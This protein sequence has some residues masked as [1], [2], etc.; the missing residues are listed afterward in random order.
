[1]RKALAARPSGAAQKELEKAEETALKPYSAAVATRKEK[2]RLESEKQAR[3]CAAEWKADQQLD[4]IARYLEREYEFDGGY[5]EMRGES[6]RLRPLIR[7]ALIE[8]LLKNPTMTA[9]Q[10]RQSIEH[11]IENGV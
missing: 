8:D 10:M 1:V 2:K 6:E 11:Q 4:H 3:R 5:L 9:D 7:R